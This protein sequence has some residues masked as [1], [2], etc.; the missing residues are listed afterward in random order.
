M[1]QGRWRSRTFTCS[2]PQAHI[3]PSSQPPASHPAIEPASQPASQPPL[4][5]LPGT[6]LPG[7]ILPHFTRTFPS[8]VPGPRP[9]SQFHP[10]LGARIANSCLP[11]I[12]QEISL[13]WKISGRWHRAGPLGGQVGGEV[14]RES[15]A[16]SS[17]LGFQ[18]LGVGRAE[19][20]GWLSYGIDPG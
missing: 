13:D 1:L 16:G 12:S 10:A 20:D 5:G 8:C 17:P 11:K 18:A 19:V 9:F 2:F 4:A 6:I 14:D 7:T 3:Q 15:P